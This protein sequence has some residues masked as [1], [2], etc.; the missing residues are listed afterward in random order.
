MNKSQL[1]ILEK[2]IEQFALY[3]EKRY[4]KTNLEDTYWVADM[5]GGTIAIA[6]YF[7][8]LD[9]MM[10]FIRYNYSNDDMFNYYQYA[11]DTYG[12]KK[13]TVCIRDW[14]KLVKE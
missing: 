12:D 2:E 10:S 8:T 7:F 1:P 13:I 14:R 5:I 9:D 3:F 6:D 11:I 4:F